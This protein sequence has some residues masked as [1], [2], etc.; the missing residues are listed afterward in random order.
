MKAGIA[1]LRGITRVDRV[2]HDPDIIRGKVQ[3]LKRAKQRCIRQGFEHRKIHMCRVRVLKGAGFEDAPDLIWRSDNH[4]DIGAYAL[5]DDIVH[6]FAERCFIEG[7]FRD[8]IP[9]LDIGLHV[10][11]GSFGEREPEI[12]HGHA[13]LPGGGNTS[14]QDDVSLHGNGMTS[15]VTVRG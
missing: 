7:R 2:A 9:A 14:Q 11:Q 10:E 13:I 1:H 3:L 6:A 8:D 5:R 15:H 4:R 12:G